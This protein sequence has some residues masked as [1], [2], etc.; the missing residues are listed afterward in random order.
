MELNK[1]NIKF[2]FENSEEYKTFVEPGK[3]YV[4]EEH[5]E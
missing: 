4:I 1:E 2:F 5:G 3:I